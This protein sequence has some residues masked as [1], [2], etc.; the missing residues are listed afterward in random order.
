MRPKLRIRND[1]G[2]NFS[3]FGC[4]SAAHSETFRESFDEKDYDAG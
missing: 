3:E 2:T 1:S 4:F